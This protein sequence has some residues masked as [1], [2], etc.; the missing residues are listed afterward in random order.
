M[1]KITIRSEASVVY[2]LLPRPNNSYSIYC[3]GPCGRD[4]GEIGYI[5]H[6]DELNPVLELHGPLGMLGVITII[7]GLTEA[8]IIALENPKTP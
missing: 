6:A 3:V 5:H 1:N 4:I 7:R 8:Q 2:T